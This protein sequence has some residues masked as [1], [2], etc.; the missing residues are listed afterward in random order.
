M[1]LFNTAEAYW[2]A[3]QALSAK[4]LEGGFADSPVRTL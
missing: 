1:G 3:A 4:K 2:K